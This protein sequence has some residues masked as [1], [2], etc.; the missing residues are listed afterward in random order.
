[1]KILFAPFAVC[2][3]LVSEPILAGLPGVDDV[4]ETAGKVGTLGMQGLLAFMLLV[5]GWVIWYQEKRRTADRAAR[6]TEVKAQYTNLLTHHEEFARK[7]E[8]ERAGF[9]AEMKA[10]AQELRGLTERSIVAMHAM[11][12]STDALREWLVQNQRYE[13]DLPPQRP[14]DPPKPQLLNP[15]SKQ[16]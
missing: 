12:T 3:W 14:Q 15:H 4:A 11:A 2:A 10:H 5:L 1:M 7:A 16:S 8:L 13:C 9:H 6:D